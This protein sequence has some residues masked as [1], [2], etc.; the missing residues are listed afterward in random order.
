MAPA[1]AGPEMLDGTARRS[2]NGRMN[3]LNTI[4]GICHGIIR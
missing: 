1:A 2:H 4:C 3:G